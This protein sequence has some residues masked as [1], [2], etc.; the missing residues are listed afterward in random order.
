MDALRTADRSEVTLNAAQ[1]EF[2]RALPV[3]TSK[4]QEWITRE[5]KRQLIHSCMICW[6]PKDDS[7]YPTI[8]AFQAGIV[9]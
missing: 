7:W 6:D 2:I 9:S 8:R 4:A 1:I 3:H 5:E